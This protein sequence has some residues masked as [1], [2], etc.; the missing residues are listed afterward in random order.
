M[1]AVAGRVGVCP[2]GEGRLA[3][4]AWGFAWGYEV[5]GGPESGD[6]R[7]LD[8]PPASYAADDHD[9][10]VI[11]CAA[12]NKKPSVFCMFTCRK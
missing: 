3:S 4:L 1:A 8:P 10:G 12:N 11:F 6:S 5:Q 9:A 2:A 7:D